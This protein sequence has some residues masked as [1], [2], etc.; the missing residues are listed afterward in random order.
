MRRELV[1]KKDSK[2]A[3]E[4]EQAAKEEEAEEKPTSQTADMGQAEEKPMS[5]PSELKPM[6]RHLDVRPAKVSRV[7]PEIEMSGAAAA[8]S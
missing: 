7:Q 6:S 1:Q 4:L 8:K 3:R 2:D 5:A